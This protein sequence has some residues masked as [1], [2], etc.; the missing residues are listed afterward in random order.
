MTTV[1]D[2]KQKLLFGKSL[3]AV[4][5][6]GILPSIYSYT[7]FHYRTNQALIHC[8][9]NCI[10]WFGVRCLTHHIDEATDKKHLRLTN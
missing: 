10:N 8:E 7:F 5:G 3:S 4:F 1:E 2:I 9:T 6:T